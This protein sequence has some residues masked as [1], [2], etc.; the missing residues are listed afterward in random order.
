MTSSR[1][2][3]GVQKLIAL[4]ALGLAYSIHPQTPAAPAVPT[5]VA[6]ADGAYVIN[7][8]DKL[9]W[10]RCVQGMRWDGRKC[11]GKAT[12]MTHAQATALAKS[13]AQADG[14]PWRLPTV[15]EFKRLAEESATHPSLLPAAPDEWY[16]VSTVNVATT[17]VNPY[18]YGSVMKGQTQANPDVTTLPTGWAVNLGTGKARSDVNRNAR[19]PVLLV[20]TQ[21]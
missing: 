16:W 1:C 3:T 21:D 11:V 15:L 5:W 4:A 17:T 7:L 18:N 13:R 12:P 19:L 9:A 20:S 6:T 14:V 2:V 10:I 8:A